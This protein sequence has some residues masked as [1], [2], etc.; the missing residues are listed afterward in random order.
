MI[1][2]GKDRMDLQGDRSIDANRGGTKIRSGH[3]RFAVTEGMAEYTP[4][5]RAS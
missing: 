1:L 2:F 4:N 3:L 5:A